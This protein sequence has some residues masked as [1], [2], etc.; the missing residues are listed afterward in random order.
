MDT[1]SD[2]SSQIIKAIIDSPEF[3]NA[4][5]AIVNEITAE[6]QPKNDDYLMTVDELRSYIPGYPAKQTVY[7]WITKRKIPYEK[8]D[9]RLYFR[10]STINKWLVNGRR[11]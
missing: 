3:H 7:D 10:K 1:S 5:T 11:L 2:L 4:V 6:K 9:S 8:Y